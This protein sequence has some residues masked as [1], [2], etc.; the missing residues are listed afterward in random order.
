MLRIKWR[1][2]IADGHQSSSAVFCCKNDD[3]HAQRSP[4]AGGVMEPGRKALTRESVR[5]KAMKN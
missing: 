5:K 3:C 1:K 2:K 4:V